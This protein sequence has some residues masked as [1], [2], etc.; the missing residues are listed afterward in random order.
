[1]KKFNVPLKSCKGLIGETIRI[2]R[3]LLT[4]FFFQCA[5]YDHTGLYMT[6]KDSTP[7]KAFKGSV[8]MYRKDY[9]KYVVFTDVLQSSIRDI[10]AIELDWLKEVAGHYYDFGDDHTQADKDDNYEADRMANFN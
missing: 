8:I 1:M 7:F 2:R 9:P 3:C 10:S 4:G 6:L 5:R